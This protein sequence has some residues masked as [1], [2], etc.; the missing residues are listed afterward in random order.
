MTGELLANRAKMGHYSTRRCLMALHREKQ[1]RKLAAAIGV[2]GRPKT[3]NG[4]NNVGEVDHTGRMIEA[5]EANATDGTLLADA[6]EDLHILG[7][8]AQDAGKP[9]DRAELANQ[10]IGRETI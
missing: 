1:V 2:T 4:V 9:D 5:L 10:I 6:V 3:V 8:A 7:E